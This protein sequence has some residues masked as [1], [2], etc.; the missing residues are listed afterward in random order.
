MNRTIR[1]LALLLVVISGVCLGLGGYT[2]YYA[3]GA[4]YLSNDPK[5]CVNCH[6]M[7][8]Q[9]TGW[10]KSSH[11]AVATCNDCHVPHDFFRKYLAKGENGWHHSRAFTMQDFHE[12]IMIKSRN[13]AVLQENCLHCHQALVDELVPDRGP[14]GGDIQCAK[15]H[16]DVGHGP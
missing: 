12:P 6:I 13:A 1:L 10:L 8:D 16:W 4:S 7:N 14:H 3:K 15:C 5:A 11:H 2:F 9:Y